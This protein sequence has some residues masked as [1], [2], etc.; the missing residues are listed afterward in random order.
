MYALTKFIVIFPTTS[1]D[2]VSAEILKALAVTI[3]RGS[4]RT[5]IK[6][7]ENQRPGVSKLQV[8]TQLTILLVQAGA[9]YMQSIM[10]NIDFSFLYRSVKTLVYSANKS[11]MT[12]RIKESVW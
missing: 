12:F 8:V 11:L 10:Q 5:P 4:F 1:K 3:A 9:D 7:P 6:Q 2:S